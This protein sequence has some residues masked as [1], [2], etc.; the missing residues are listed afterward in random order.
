MFE[1]EILS[2]V[3]ASRLLDISLSLVTVTAAFL[4][5]YLLGLP[6]LKTL[7]GFIKQE[8]HAEN[9]K[10]FEIP[11]FILPTF[12]LGF[13]F[14]SVALVSCGLT[15]WVI[16]QDIDKSD[17]ESSFGV[18]RTTN[19]SDRVQRVLLTINEYDGDSNFG[20]FVNGYQFFGSATHCTLNFQCRPQSDQLAEERYSSYKAIAYE[21][22][23]THHIR[24]PHS[25]PHDLDVTPLLVA[26]DNLIDIHSGYSSGSRCKLSISLK[27]IS[28]GTTKVNVLRVE[29]SDELPLPPGRVEL[30]PEEVFGGSQTLS[31]ASQPDGAQTSFHPRFGAQLEP[32]S[33][34]TFHPRYGTQLEPRLR[35]I[36]ERIR[37]VL[38]MTQQQHDKIAATVDFAAWAL[39]R[40][41]SAR[42]AYEPNL[43]GCLVTQGSS[44]DNVRP[45]PR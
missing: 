25:L 24:D 45:A 15:L 12:A 39:E 42:C 1:P 8:A 43:E 5:L 26:G 34:R 21:G 31:S 7:L 27:Q 29:D 3:G 18:I 32:R 13:L 28:D 11:R 9:L 41:K 2:G 33:H 36:C 16:G 10:G 22:H 23:T 17:Y 38:D 40:R 30:K 37:V 6:P 35:R 4:F 44:P 14:I 20:V 19:L